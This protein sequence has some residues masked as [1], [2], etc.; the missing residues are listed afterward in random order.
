MRS[1]TPVW[2]FEESWKSHGWDKFDRRDLARSRSKQYWAGD[3]RDSNTLH[4]E[5][6]SAHTTSHHSST[7]ASQG[8]ERCG[9]VA[10]ANGRAQSDMKCV[11]SEH[12]VG[13]YVTCTLVSACCFTLAWFGVLYPMEQ[14]V[15]LSLVNMSN[16][17]CFVLIYI[18]Q[19]ILTM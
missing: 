13:K 1:I 12:N 15:K 5:L 3:R 17:D 16:G 7:G 9:A 6:S 14:W 19:Y 8:S 2:K 18:M 10:I 11:W 4:R